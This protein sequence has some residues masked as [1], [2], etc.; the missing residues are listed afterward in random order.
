MLLAFTHAGGLDAAAIS[1][2]WS[3]ILV[4]WPTT[5]G[6]NEDRTIT[7]AVGGAR[8]IKN[9][10]ATGGTLEYRINSGTWT[11]YTQGGAGFSMTSGQT[12]GW[13]FTPG[14]DLGPGDAA[15][16]VNG[17]ALDTFTLQGSGFP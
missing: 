6:T 11:T 16:T 13:R 10:W 5:N 9:G 1:A 8:T 17:I 4:A 2:V 15:V 14:G 7:W 12:L 3:D